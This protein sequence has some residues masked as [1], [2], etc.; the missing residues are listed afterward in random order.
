MISKSAFC[1]HLSKSPGPPIV[2]TGAA[3]VS[4]P[5][6]LFFLQSLSSHLC[7]YEAESSTLG[8]CAQFQFLICKGTVVTGS[9][10]LQL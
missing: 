3:D 6:C 7:V 5:L 1:Q 2:F 10:H 9:D 4:V 8:V